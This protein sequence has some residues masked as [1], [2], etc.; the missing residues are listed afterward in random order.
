[1]LEILIAP[2][3][4]AALLIGT[5]GYVFWHGDEAA[6]DTMALL[7]MCWL[8]S[9]YVYGVTGSHL[10]PG[11]GLIDFMAAGSLYLLRTRRWQFVVL[12]L[13]AAMMFIHAAAYY[14]ILPSGTSYMRIINTLFC[15]QLIVPAFV[16]WQGRHEGGWMARIPHWPAARAWL[17]AGSHFGGEGA[18]GA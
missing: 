4:I 7:L 8:S 11:Y 10:I 16:V 13:F 5:A 2:W 9:W 14:G 17:L 12:H 15:L 18:K 1:M 6:R 3:L